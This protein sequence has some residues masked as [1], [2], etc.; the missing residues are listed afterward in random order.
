[1]F[2][3]GAVA[4]ECFMLEKKGTGGGNLQLLEIKDNNPRTHQYMIQVNED[5]H[6][7]EKIYLKNNKIFFI[8]KHIQNLRPNLSIA[9]DT[10]KNELRDLLSVSSYNRR[11]A[12]QILKSTYFY[13]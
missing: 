8:I 7:F 6:S 2:A 10:F 5:L 12:R 1:M 4:Y 11:D 9:P 3:L 13:R